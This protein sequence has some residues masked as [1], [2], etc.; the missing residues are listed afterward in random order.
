VARAITPERLAAVIADIAGDRVDVGPLPAGPGGA[1]SA[2]AVGRIG[3]IE[4]RRVDDLVF[5]ATIP[6]ELALTVRLAGRPHRYEASVSV[7]LRITV[8]LEAPV[9][10]VL[11]V[12]KV[13]GREVRAVLRS[14][15]V[16]AGIIGQ[17]GDMRREVARQVAHYVNERATAA[18]EPRRIDIGRMIDQVWDTDVKEQFLLR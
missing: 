5:E 3:V 1:A 18:T 12:Q 9:T 8:A 11:D 16:A 4:A 2:R 6:V 15:G 7:P 14:S 10:L 13:R 17:L